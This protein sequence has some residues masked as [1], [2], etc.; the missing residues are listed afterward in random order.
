MSGPRQP[1]R[2]IRADPAVKAKSLSGG[3]LPGHQL[4]VT[5]LLGPAIH[6]WVPVTLAH[7]PGDGGK[8]VREAEQKL[9]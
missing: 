1:G 7:E 8:P 2:A 9:L 6:A 4:A 5:F 3:P